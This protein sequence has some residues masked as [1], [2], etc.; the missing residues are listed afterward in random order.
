MKKIEKILKTSLSN[1]PVENKDYTF[2]DLKP[3]SHQ[4]IILEDLDFSRKE[5]D[6]YRNLV[7]SATGTGKTM[8][9]GFDF[10]KILS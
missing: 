9:A 10:K 8:V 6:S 2:F 7:V 3:F 1:I 5:L 4:K